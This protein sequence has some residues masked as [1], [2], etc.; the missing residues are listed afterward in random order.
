ML[1]TALTFSGSRWA[2]SGVIDTSEKY[3]RGLFDS[4]CIHVEDMSIFTGN[5]HEFVETFVMF[6]VILSI[7][8]IIC[9][10]YHSIAA[11]E[12][13]VHHLLEAFLC[14]GY[15]PGEADKS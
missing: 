8:Y 2:S 3:Y 13:L 12:D 1:W 15:A 14:T 5:S 11:D 7:N 6:L 4:T 9:N 10:V